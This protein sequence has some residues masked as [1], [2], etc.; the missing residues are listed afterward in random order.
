MPPF[1]L[2]YSLLHPSISTSKRTRCF[3][4]RQSGNSRCSTDS[5]NRAA[6]P[7]QIGTSTQW[8]WASAYHAGSFN[9]LSIMSFS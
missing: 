3:H 6:K 5:G 9:L 7:F 4:L 2:R 8:R 1:C